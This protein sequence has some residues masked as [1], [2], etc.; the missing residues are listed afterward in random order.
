MEMKVPVVFLH[1][2]VQMKMDYMSSL[3]LLYV[4]YRQAFLNTGNEDNFFVEISFTRAQTFFCNRVTS[5]IIA[6]L[7]QGSCIRRD[8]AGKDG[9]K[10]RD[11]ILWAQENASDIKGLNNFL[12]A[13]HL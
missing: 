7:F 8:R 13:Y 4:C 11:Q 1:K 6:L 10:R 2:I 3:V 12:H 9:T 5:A